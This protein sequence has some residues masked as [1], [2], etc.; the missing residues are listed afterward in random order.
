MAAKKK[1]P[2]AGRANAK[3]N[4]SGAAGVLRRPFLISVGAL[5]LAEEQVSSLVDSLTKRGEKA[6][7]L[8]EK[9][10]KKLRKNSSDILKRVQKKEENKAEP[11]DD[12]ILRALHWLNVPTHDDIVALDK[13][14]DALLRKV[15]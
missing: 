3:K 6:Q 2:A 8:G 7:K 9:Y 4:G 14:V 12:L 1:A 5:A 10:F 13:K 15:A 11:K